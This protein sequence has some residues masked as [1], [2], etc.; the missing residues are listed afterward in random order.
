ML[1]EIYIRNIAVI[2]ELRLTFGTGFHVLTGETG[3]GKSIL[4]ESI[5][6]ILG[7]KAR[8][9]LLRDGSQTAT[10]EAVFDLVDFPEVKAQLEK[11]GFLNSEDVDEFVIRRQ[12]Q[13]D[14]K[15]KVYL[16][17]QRSSLNFLQRVTRPL[18]D[19]TGQHQQIELLDSRRDLAVLDQ[20]HANDSLLAEYQNSFQA[21][22]KLHQELDILQR[23]I[24]EKNERMEWIRY[25]LKELNELKINSAEQEEELKSHR[26]QLKHLNAIQSFSF[27]VQNAL[28]NGENSCLTQLDTV[29]RDFE[30]MPFLESFLSSA[31][32][33]RINDLRIQ[34]E[35]VAY[36][37]A[38]SVKQ[39]ES[40][41]ENWSLDEI[42]AQLYTLEKLKRKFGPELSDVLQKKSDLENEK[43]DLEHSDENLEELKKKFQKEFQNLQQL[44]KKLSLARQEVAQELQ[45]DVLKE[46]GALKMASARFVIEV[47]P[48]K[49]EDDFSSYSLRGYDD[50]TFLLSPNPGLALKPLA[51]IASGGE[52]SR[53]F[54]ALKQILTKPLKSGTLI[55]DEV[56]T[57][58][59]GAVIELIGKKLKNLAKRLQVFCITHHAQIASLA[60]HHFLVSKTIE[61]E[62][63]YTKVTSLSG[64]ERV[65]EV[66]RLMGGVKITDKN[67]EY[68]REMV[69]KAKK[70]A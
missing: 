14:G 32:K 50:V 25:Q 42:E 48:A 16:N 58:I 30:K 4:V 39:T 27:K 46:L 49:Q 10:V 63:T 62:Q 19:Y 38:K 29:L 47:K 41:D 9:P 7:E 57:G 60:D 68:A 37:V 53:I 54:L 28:A 8:A 15:N 70:S 5:G 22:K 36:D 21:A 33:D 55:F 11:E 1:K 64:E 26:E 17:H 13:A 35:D 69:L 6:L 45:K 34:I 12:I 18:I 66:A 23:V 2:D 44:A 43:Q 52:T 51:K 59:S 56:D 65:E 40:F 20:F 31:I 3:A 61:N 67:R 24:L